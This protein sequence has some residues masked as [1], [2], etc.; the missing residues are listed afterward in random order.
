MSQ[1][2]AAFLKRI[3]DESAYPTF[4]MFVA[5]IEVLAVI[6]AVLAGVIAVFWRERL[7][8]AI[9]GLALFG[10]VALAFIAV[11]A[12]EAFL[13]LADIA[14]AILDSAPKMQGGAGGTVVDPSPKT[15]VEEAVMP[16]WV[17]EAIKERVKKP[18]AN[19]EPEIR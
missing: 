16:S 12:A 10:A 18:A 3:R 1:T 9:I 4:R 17:K 6:M 14:D 2:K 19:S 7:P 13:M 11:A 5:C 8:P 15:P